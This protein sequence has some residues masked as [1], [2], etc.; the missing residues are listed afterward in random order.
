LTEIGLEEERIRMVNLSSAMGS[1]FVTST[2]EMFDVIKKI[3]PNPLK[4]NGTVKQASNSAG[5]RELLE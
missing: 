3:G 5:S 1:Q 4:S 2:T